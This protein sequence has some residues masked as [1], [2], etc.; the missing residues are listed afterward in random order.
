[1][2]TSRWNDAD[3]R[4]NGAMIPYTP[5]LDNKNAVI[6]G[7]GNVSIDC[8]RILLSPIEKLAQTDIPEYALKV[9]RQSKV[10]NINIF[11]RRGPR[12]VCLHSFQTAD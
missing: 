8:S 1:M 4:Y 11:G 12:E 7:N 3:F 5:L 9:L 10:T 2:L 6:I